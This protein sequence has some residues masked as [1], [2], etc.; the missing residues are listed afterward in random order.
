MHSSTFLGPFTYQWFHSLLSGIVEKIVL[1]T[2][3]FLSAR[4][5]LYRST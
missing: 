2:G 1:S 5:F 3:N 4:N